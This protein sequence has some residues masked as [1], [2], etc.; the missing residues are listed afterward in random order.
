M[1]EIDQKN[2]KLYRI[3]EV[4]FFITLI[5]ISGEISLRDIAIGLLFI[6]FMVRKVYR[7]DFSLVSTEYNKYIYLFFIF[8]LLSLFKAEDLIQAGHAIVTPIFTY[9]VF[10]FMAL[11]IVKEK[12]IGKY[13]KYLYL[14]NIIFLIYGLYIDIYTSD[15]FFLSGNS[16][17]TFAGFII[18]IS[19]SLFITNRGKLYHKFTYVLGFSL[20]VFALFSHS[21]GA[22]VGFSIGIV[23]WAILMIFKSFSWKRVVIT[24][25][26]LLAIFTVFFSSD[27]IVN[28]FD[29]ILRY[30]DDNSITTRIR[31][32]RTSYNLIKENP[33]LGIG[34]GNFTPT[35]HRYVQEVMSE[36]A[37]SSI[38]Q[39]PHNLYL[40]IPLEQG[41]ISLII[42]LVLIYKTYYI[43]FMNY[44]FFQERSWPYFAA[45]TQ[46]S[47]LTAILGHSFFDFPLNR[48]FNGV[49]LIL[50]IILNFRY[51]NRIRDKIK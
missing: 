50:L 5:A 1:T 32:W 14:G 21:R 41:I 9:I 20:G 36:K 37:W 45:I 28:R 4:M 13:V 25:M 34:A 51:Y 26:I 19:L 35:A 49:P 38:H 17:G 8:S 47:M 7:K 39:H 11:E 42:F 40:Q 44:L 18:F 10:Y 24:L 29:R 16:R 3:L 12:K 15:R 33:V 27:A 30:Q 23:V 22:I 43:S 6:I 2:D 46:I 31:M 48:S